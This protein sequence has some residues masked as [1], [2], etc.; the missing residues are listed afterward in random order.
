MNVSFA[1]NGIAIV[2]D[3]YNEKELQLI[4]KELNYLT[5]S[6]T[7]LMFGPNK[8]HRSSGVNGRVA[9][10]QAAARLSTT[11]WFFAVFAKLRVED[12][13]DWSCQPDRLRTDSL[14]D[15]MRL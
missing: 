14:S 9:A 13:F 2:E 5:L 10:Y 15:H 12:N 8:I 7:V 4:W 6:N 3:F 11:P 1:G